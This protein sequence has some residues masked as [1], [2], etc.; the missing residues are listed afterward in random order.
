MLTKEL[1]IFDFE[2]GRL[3]PDRLVRSAH[4]H[5]LEYARRMLEIYA[6]GIGQAR[7]E[8]HA[9]VHRVF[10]NEPDCPPQRID[11]FC[12]LL[13]EDG[14]AKYDTDRRGTA[15]AL[16]REVFH[17]AAASHP[18]VTQRDALFEHAE[19]DVKQ[20]IAAELGAASWEAIEHDL[21]KDVIEYNRLAAFTGY[22]S[23]EALLARYNVA[24]IQAA[25]FSAVRLTIWARADLKRIVTHAKL[26]RLLLSIAPPRPGILD[27][28]YVITLD[29]PASV[30]RE[31]RRY[32]A[33][34]AAFLPA[35]LACKDWRLRADL[36][37]GKFQ[38][39]CR[40]ELSSR[41]GLHSPIAPQA[42]FDAAIEA[43]FAKKWGDEPRNGWTMKREG[44]ILHRDQ[45]VMLPDFAFHHEDGRSA[46][47]EIVGF[48]TP[49]YLH[50]KLAKLALFK[51]EPIIIAA[52]E[53]AAEK[54]E[55]AAAN[56]IL[57][58]TVLKLDP[59][60]AALERAGSAV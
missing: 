29:G 51:D 1:A 12:K 22:P 23:P 45:V 44:A 58:K 33:S 35:L 4:D 32:G 41:D 37:V 60:L 49:E 59:V 50:A 48:W 47:L 52:A 54:W 31:T 34:M 39:T 9:A 53:R 20:A 25:L 19:S 56:L 15:A 6:G 13:D 8:L 42:E 18:L 28:D 11:A 17:R 7:H 16:R 14:I 21:F 5:Y 30:L 40:L 10:A 36:L 43:G 2:R 46:W 3:V 26:A 24:Q 27:D 55:G 38:R 57:Y